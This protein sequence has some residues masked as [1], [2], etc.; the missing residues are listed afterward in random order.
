MVTRV[1]DLRHA[2]PDALPTGPRDTDPRCKIP[3]ETAKGTQRCYSVVTKDEFAVAFREQLQT[4]RSRSTLQITQSSTLS[5]REWGINLGGNQNVVRERTTGGDIGGSRNPQWDRL[6]SERPERS[7][8]CPDDRG[9]S[10][11]GRRGL[12]VDRGPVRRARTALPRSQRTGSCVNTLTTSSSSYAA[13]EVA[14][15]LAAG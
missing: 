15:A 14:N 6:G 7:R 1:G 9:G 8:S 2:S 11:R 3:G 5:P 4:G 12:S 10:R 13:T